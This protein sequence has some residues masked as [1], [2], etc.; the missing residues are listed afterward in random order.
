[1][2]GGHGAQSD[3]GRRRVA[4]GVELGEVGEF[5]PGRPGLGEAGRHL[6]VR[7]GKSLP[8]GVERQV[9]EVGPVQH[10]FDLDVV[11]F[12]IAAAD[13]AQNQELAGH[14]QAAEIVPRVRFRVAE[15]VGF[16]DGFAP[17]A[18]GA[19]LAGQVGERA[20]EHARHAVDAVA[21]AE[22]HVGGVEHRQARSD[23][24]LVEDVP[25]AGG[26]EGAKV[27]DGPREGELVRAGDG[28]AGGEGA[29][30]D[31]AHRAAGGDVDEHGAAAAGRGL[32]EVFQQAVEVGRLAAPLERAPP[33]IG[34]DCQA[35]IETLAA[36][37][38]QMHETGTGQTPQLEIDPLPRERV[39]LGG[40]LPEQGGTDAADAQHVDGKPAGGGPVEEL[41]VDPAHGSSLVGPVDDHRDVPLGR[42][43]GHR[44]HVHRA[45]PEDPEHPAG[46]ARAL[47]H[48]VADDGDD[49]LV[50]LDDRAPDGSGLDLGAELGLDR[51]A[52][53]VGDAGL[54]R[55]ADR[56]LAG[57]LGDEDRADSARRQG[58]EQ[59]RGDS[60]GADQVV[61]DQQH[62]VDVVDRGDA[63]DRRAAGPLP[64][65]AAV[66]Q[67]SRVFGVEGAAHE[68]GDALAA[69]RSDRRRIDHLGAEVGEFEHLL[70]AQARDRQR[71]LDAFRIGRHHSRHVRPDLDPLGVERRA[72]Q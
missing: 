6:A 56:V 34:T 13:A 3:P 18:A 28:G 36:P 65:P 21:G 11:Q 26:A 7:L 22:Q 62:Q 67:R 27:G 20:R 9:G 25:G 14:V 50:A 1:M 52:R 33:A 10:G 23:G 54:D 60:R 59:P 42:A 5:E 46:D 61:A 41:P 39:P 53:R 30:V 38:L 66:D 47:A 32:A 19:Q 16:P 40:Q 69:G 63:G 4:R 24:R 70:V 29:P 2:V 8:P 15:A 45:P 71:V 48:A 12:E 68:Q 57:G 44:P 49:R 31:G 72:D 51:L 35:G 58:V 37:G 64:V 43:L 55:E 17:D